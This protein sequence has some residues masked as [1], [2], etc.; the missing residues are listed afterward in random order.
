MS[1]TKKNE[2]F[3][4]LKELCRIMKTTDLRSATRWC[5]EMKI[6]ILVIGSKKLTYRFLVEAKLDNPI[7]T[8]FKEQYPESWDKLYACYLNN[9]RLEFVMTTEA[10]T[11]KPN[12]M[13]LTPKS[14]FAKK[15]LDE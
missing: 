12:P 6:P 5:K 14:D 8:L 1:S 3:I 11:E 13:N 10:D 9:E 2:K 7:I 4:E 15:F